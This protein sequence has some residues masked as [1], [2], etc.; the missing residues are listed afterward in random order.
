M[1]GA[2]FAVDVVATL[3]C[4]F[5]WLSGEYETTSP[6]SGAEFSVN[7][8]VDIVT[9]VVIW[10]YSI[11]VTIVIGVVYYLLTIVPALDNLGR[12]NR[13]KADTQLENMLTYLSKLAVEHEVGGQ[14]RDRYILGAR[15]D[16]DGSE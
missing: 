3:F 1:V 6:P 9:V 11:G 16:E 4:V 5:G 12:K 15:V 14:L 7:G 13:S 10:A 8:D 2:I